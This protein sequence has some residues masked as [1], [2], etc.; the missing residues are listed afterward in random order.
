VPSFSRVVDAEASF[1]D[2]LLHVAFAVRRRGAPGELAREV[3]I[4]VGAAFVG[5][6]GEVRLALIP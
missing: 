3:V 1:T 6:V 5:D 2:R 4:A